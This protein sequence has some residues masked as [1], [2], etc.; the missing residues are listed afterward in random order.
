M[1]TGRITTQAL[2]SGWPRRTAPESFFA[3]FRA[4]N[5]ASY[6]NAI[7]AT[8]GASARFMAGGPKKKGRPGGGRL[9]PAWVLPSSDLWFFL[10]RRGGAGPV[11][12]NLA[13]GLTRAP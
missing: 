8:P 9:P 5:V 3:R 2:I 10:G 1:A 4:V 6:M 13:F 7:S 11:A 12:L